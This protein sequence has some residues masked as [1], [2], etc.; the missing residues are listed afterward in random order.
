VPPALPGSTLQPQM[1]PRRP[2]GFFCVAHRLRAPL[3]AQRARAAIAKFVIRV[4][5]NA[6]RMMIACELCEPGGCRC[7]VRCDVNAI[8][9]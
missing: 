5:L 2:A 8:A 7:R 1:L 3:F 9:K 4:A 6:C